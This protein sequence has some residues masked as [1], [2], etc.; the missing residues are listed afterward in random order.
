QR[1]ERVVCEPVP[2]GRRLAHSYVSNHVHCVF[3][4]KDRQPLVSPEMQPRLWRFI[5]TVAENRGIKALAVGGTE[6]HLHVLIAVPATMALAKAIQTLK[7]VSSKWMN[8]RKRGFAW[9]KV[10]APSAST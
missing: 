7:G 10:M 5:A 2:E 8:E 4:T 9:R 3:S 1:W 6:N